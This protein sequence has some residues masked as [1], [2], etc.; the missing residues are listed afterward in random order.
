MKGKEVGEGRAENR[1]RKQT[2]ILTL[3]LI[4]YLGYYFIKTGI[5]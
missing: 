3:K 5:K 1:F 2:K 4:G